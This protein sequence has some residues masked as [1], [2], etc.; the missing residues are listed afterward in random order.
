MAGLSM[1]VICRGTKAAVEEEKGTAGLG[2]GKRGSEKL[3]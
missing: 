1:V 2:G 3:D